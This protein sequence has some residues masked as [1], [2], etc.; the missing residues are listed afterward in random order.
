MTASIPHCFLSVEDSSPTPR[1]HEK[2][3]SLLGPSGSLSPLQYLQPAPE[4]RM[5]FHGCGFHIR[6]SGARDG[7]EKAL[8]PQ[9][10]PKAP[11]T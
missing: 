9:E 7:E 5:E 6:V 4:F 1:Y 11:A 10:G 2:M 3:H 8:E